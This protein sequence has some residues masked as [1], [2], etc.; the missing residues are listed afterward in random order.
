[1]KLSTANRAFLALLALSLVAVSALALAAVSLVGIA[2]YRAFAEPGAAGPLSGHDLRPLAGFLVPVG[3]GALL[4]WRSARRQVAATRTLTR[5]VEELRVPQPPE[6]IVAAKR[7][8]MARRR[9]DVVASDEPFSF[10][11]GLVV[12]RVVV[13]EGLLSIVSPTELDAVLEHE[14]YHVRNLDPLKVVLARVLPSA[15]FFL[16]ALRDLRRRYVA[17]RE[18][19]ADRRAVSVHGRTALAGA[20]LKVVKGPGWSELAAAAAIGGQELLDVRVEQLETGREPAM[21]GVSRLLAL[22]STVVIGL[23]VWSF[24]WA[25]GDF[26]GPAGDVFGHA[27][28]SMRLGWGINPLGALANV[29]KLGFW[30]WIAILTYRGLVRRCGSGSSRPAP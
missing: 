15:L 23:L 13:S 16:P 2:A 18:L 22:V 8:G 28:P 3:L 30:V 19:A 17:G 26:G 27:M 11:Y 12:P 9:I 25:L 4:G 6:V 5:K 7:T 29:A 20:L 21:P 1:M 10:A 24:A 14:R